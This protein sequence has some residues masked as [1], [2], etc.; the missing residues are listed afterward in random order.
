MTPFRL[1]LVRMRNV[2]DKSCG[3]NQNTHFTFKKFFSKIVLF[4]RPCKT[5]IWWRHTGHMTIYGACAL[6]AGEN[7]ATD[8]HSE[9]IILIVFPR[10]QWLGYTYPYIAYLVY[11]EVSSNKHVQ[12]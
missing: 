4:T 1:I 11:I 10:Q 6:N 2:S 8:K 3:E 7:K 12:N 5:K 9:Y